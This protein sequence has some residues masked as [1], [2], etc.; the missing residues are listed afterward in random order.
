MNLNGKQ[1]TIPEL[2]FNAMCQL[3]E[4]GVA[5]V[6]LDKKVMSTIR[7]FL[8]LAMRT[9]I[10]TAGKALET[11]IINGGDLTEI[12]NEINKA[13]EESGFFQALQQKQ[14]TS[15]PAGKSKKTAQT[16]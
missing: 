13:V 7:G 9:D 10:D 1:Y 4:M 12:M 15:A 11:H 2:D 14:K 3:E 6:S 8:A 5:L 16:A